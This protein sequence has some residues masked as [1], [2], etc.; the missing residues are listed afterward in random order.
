MLV[1]RPGA[2]GD[3]IVTMPALLA[4]RRQFPA[5]QIELAGNPAVLPL[6]VSS[7]LADRVVSFDDGR[8]MRLFVPSEPQ[9]DDPFMGTDVAVA[10]CADP[11]RTLEWALRARGASLTVVSPSRPPPARPIHVAR[12]LIETLGPLGPVGIDPDGP[13]GAL[14]VPPLRTSTSV[15]RQA[16][17][18]LRARD[19]DGR[20]FVA[21]HPGSGSPA[22]N[23]PAERFGEVVAA[24]EGH[25]GLSALLLGGPADTTVLDDLRDCRDRAP[26]LLVNRPLPVV[27]AVL[28]HARVFLGNDS[29]LAHL[30][31]VL[32]VPTLALF[33]PTDPRQW[34]PLGPRVRTL[35]AES[36]TMA[37]IST[38]RV[39]A[40][41]ATLLLP[42]GG[43]EG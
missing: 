20:P 11:D 26:A 22:K 32:G 17:E 15:E 39:L 9:L 30:A 10:W 38:E 23:W 35:R 1:L 28:R 24:L 40:E 25:Y 6:L 13:N 36:T 3:T 29:G 42:D 41:L 34:R 8:V 14:D 18:E 33:G 16:G 27:A 31:G 43:S 19:L 12:H 37:G 4:L 5:A 2:I 21:I 7:G